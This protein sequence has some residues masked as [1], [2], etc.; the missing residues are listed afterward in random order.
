[1]KK[2]FL[3]LPVVAL[4]T[5]AFIPDGGNGKDGK[6]VPAVTL[7]DMQG[8]TINTADVKNDGKPIVINFWATWCK[9]CK[10]ELNAI[11][12]L[13]EDWQDETGVK[14]IAVSVDDQK[15]TNS[16]EPYVNSTGWEYDIWMDVNGDLKRAMGVNIPPQTF[17][18][19]GE[20]NIVWSHSGYV[21]GDEEELYDQILA[22]SK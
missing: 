17:L 7:K 13:Y 11:A 1:M 6:K 16:V 8:N 14:L 18:V 3:I 22:I 5:M 2:L 21:P 4:L 19:N 15:T 10:Q 9:P 12:D 20:G